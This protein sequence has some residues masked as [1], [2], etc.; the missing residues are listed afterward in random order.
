MKIKGI[1]TIALLVLMLQ[2][3]LSGCS[4]EGLG[5]GS[6]EESGKA[7]ERNWTIKVDQTIPV[8]DGD[9]TVNQTLV[10]IAQKKGG[11][12]IHGTYEGA[13][14]IGS[15]LD[16]SPLAKVLIKLSRG[17]DIDIS[18]NNLSFEI[19]PFDMK[20]YSAYGS[21]DE[22]SLAPLVQHDSMSLLLPE[23]KG[24][25]IINPTIKGID[26]LQGSYEASGGG[27]ETV[28]MKIAIKSHG[29]MN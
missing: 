21:K 23:M 26:G 27:L 3:V 9:I 11:D 25:V 2:T 5:P 7:L 20:R 22:A 18:A 29:Q 14:Y 28:P 19:E 24:G 15:H 16:I 6:S 8:K 1:V 12:N 13:A 17:F 4:P 10:L